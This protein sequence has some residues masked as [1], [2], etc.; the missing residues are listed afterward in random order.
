MNNNEY[1]YCNDENN[2]LNLYSSHDNIISLNKRNKES[3][4]K[5]LLS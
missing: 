3:I 2:I 5:L 4:Y 1:M